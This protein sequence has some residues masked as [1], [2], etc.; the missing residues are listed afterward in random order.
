MLERGIS[1]PFSVVFL[2]RSQG[3]RAFGGIGAGEFHRP[4]G[5][6]VVVVQM[7]YEPA[8]RG[9]GLGAPLATVGT[10]PDIDRA[11]ASQ[12]S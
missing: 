9:S 6:H 8:W 12:L 5:Y 4:L 10:T 3:G 7:T 11:F 1:V 2:R